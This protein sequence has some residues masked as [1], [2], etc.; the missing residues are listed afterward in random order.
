[1]GPSRESRNKPAM[2]ECP[3]GSPTQSG[4]TNVAQPNP[5]TTP[6]HRANLDYGS[7]GLRPP[8]SFPSLE[9]LRD[10][11]KEC[12]ETM[13]LPCVARA[14]GITPA[15]LT[16]FLEGGRIFDSGRR[17][18]SRWLNAAERETSAAAEAANRLE[19]LRQL[20]ETLPDKVQQAAAVRE[21]LLV[22]HR[23]YLAAAIP[24][25]DWLSRSIEGMGP[26]VK[27]TVVPTGDAGR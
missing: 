8:R 14:V 16:K 25:P 2:N 3:G 27:P 7:P 22:I 4:A 1:M 17:K 26:D 12:V 19:P 6:L 11:A 24:T 13:T 23:H 9:R 21:V 20:V 15:S 10:R 18:L 5:T